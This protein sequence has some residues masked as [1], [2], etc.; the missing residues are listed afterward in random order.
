M[1]PV[2]AIIE[3]PKGSG[4]KYNYEPDMNCFK[5][6]KVMPA[7]LVFPFDFGFIPIPKAKTATR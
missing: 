4:Y 5:L 7:G 1:K 2:T 6:S 3:S